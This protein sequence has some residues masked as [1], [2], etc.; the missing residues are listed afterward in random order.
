MERRPIGYVPWREA[1]E[2]EV[3]PPLRRRLLV[4]WRNLVKRLIRA[5]RVEWIWNAQACAVCGWRRFVVKCIKV[6]KLQDV[7]VH[8][9]LPTGIWL[10]C[11]VASAIE[12]NV[13]SDQLSLISEFLFLV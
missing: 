9:S 7:C 5:A 4:N 13:S 3:D 8:R 12:P 10:D 1:E 2:A 6:R 11:G